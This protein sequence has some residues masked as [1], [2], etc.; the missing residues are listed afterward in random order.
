MANG[1][2]GENTARHEKK[3]WF[4]SHSFY[5]SPQFGNEMLVMIRVVTFL[6]LL[7]DDSCIYIDSA[8]VTPV[9]QLFTFAESTI[10]QE[11][12]ALFSPSQLHLSKLSMRWQILQ[13]QSLPQITCILFTHT[14]PPLARLSIQKKNTMTPSL[15]N[16]TPQQCMFQTWTVIDQFLL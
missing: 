15:K 6:L 9:S 16:I 13:K 3:L 14:S 4:S 5:L 10:C 12:L 11:E 7:K 2:F 8:G 1:F